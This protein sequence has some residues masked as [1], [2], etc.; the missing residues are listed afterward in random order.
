MRGEQKL[1]TCKPACT[2]QILAGQILSSDQK[3]HLD[4]VA[5]PPCPELGVAEDK[6]AAVR[7]RRPDQLPLVLHRICG[8]IW[9]GWVL[10]CVMSR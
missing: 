6:V 8:G 3:A 4:E 2:W 5:R 10:L 1:S 9:G 7:R